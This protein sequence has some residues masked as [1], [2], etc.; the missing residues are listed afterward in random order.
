MR[1]GGTGGRTGQRRI[2]RAGGILAIVPIILAGC[3]GGRMNGAADRAS[4]SGQVMQR[5]SV[6]LTSGGVRRALAFADTT[7]VEQDSLRL[8]FRQL[9]LTIFAVEGQPVAVLTAPRASHRIGSDTVVATGGVTVATPS[10]DTLFTPTLTYLRDAMRLRSDSAATLRA[11]SGTRSGT[12]VSADVRLREVRF[13][14][15]PA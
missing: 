3:D 14:K 5:M 1:C 12:G 6:A 2:G 8:D 10:G 7:Y 15:P 9:R 4:R 11:R 13:G